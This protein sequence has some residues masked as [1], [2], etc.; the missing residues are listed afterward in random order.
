[1]DRHKVYV[2]ERDDVAMPSP[3][4]AA[5][6]LEL[7]CEFDWVSYCI[8]DLDAELESDDNWDDPKQWVSGE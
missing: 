4:S 6:Q 7:E 5:V 3:L 1:M 8:G 2:P